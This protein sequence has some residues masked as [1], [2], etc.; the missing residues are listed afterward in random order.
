MIKLEKQ[1]FLKILIVFY[2]LE[3]RYC[4]FSIKSIAL[5]NSTSKFFPLGSITENK[6]LKK[7]KGKLSKII[8][9]K[10]DL[11][12]T[13][14]D[15]ISFLIHI[16]FLNHLASNLEKFLTLY[17]NL[18]KESKKTSSIDFKLLKNSLNRILKNNS[19]KNLYFKENY[20]I[21]KADYYFQMRFFI[22]SF[23]LMSR[24][25]LFPNQKRE[26]KVFSISLEN[27]FN[28]LQIL[29]YRL[30]E[31]YFPK[32]KKCIDFKSKGLKFLDKPYLRS[33]MFECQDFVLEKTDKFLKKYFIG[34][35]NRHYCKKIFR[36]R[37]FFD[38]LLNYKKIDLKGQD[39]SQKSSF[40]KQSL[41][42]ELFR[43]RILIFLPSKTILNNLKSSIELSASLLPIN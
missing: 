43:S 5:E 8:K 7:S 28:F 11:L 40:K 17:V 30:N 15:K 32:L 16:Y 10:T 21:L 20:E 27:L 13:V 39:N 2:S 42:F 38:L 1:Y 23:Q 41:S 4:E 34:F 37:Y 24:V 31:L 3:E 22:F 6:F 14:G 33:R 18:L 36:R 9:Y 19:H 26:G 25:F 12:A 29:T 35:Q